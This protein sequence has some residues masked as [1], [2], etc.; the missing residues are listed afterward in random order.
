MDLAPLGYEH[1]QALL[2]LID[3]SAGAHV[4]EVSGDLLALLP[5]HIV[6][7]MP[8]PVNDTQ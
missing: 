8:H 5:V 2:N 3:N 4:L 7:A 1:A 6:Q